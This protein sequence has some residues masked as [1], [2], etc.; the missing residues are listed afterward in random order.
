MGLF[1]PLFAAKRGPGCGG[2]WINV[3]PLAWICQELLQFSA[4]APLL[5]TELVYRE[6]SDGMP[7][8]HYYVSADGTPAYSR[9][10]AVDQ[11]AP[12]Q[13]LEKGFAVAIVEQ[14]RHEGDLFGRT[15]HGLWIAMHDLAPVRAPTFH[16]EVIADGKLDFGWVLSNDSRVLSKPSSAARSEKRLARFQVVHILETKGSGHSTFHRIDEN[17][18]IADLNIRHPTL[19]SPPASVLGNTKWIDIELASQTLV[20]YEGTQPVYAAMVSTGRGPQGSEFATPK[21]EHRIWVK[22]VG[23]NMDNLEDE[24]A[25]NY[26]SIE[27]VPYVQYFSKGVGLHSAFWHSAFGRVKSHGCVNLPPIDAQWLFAWTSPH[28]PAG[29]NAVFPTDIEQGTLIRV[30]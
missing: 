22:L 1:L 8:R 24:D 20:A 6:V 25:T 23:S 18:W 12:D 13:E 27:D 17:A 30:R 2:R 5:P 29:W 16:G 21:G 4:N 14:R 7:F 10:N 11:T 19:V 9:L 15:R 26:Y 3:G 28:L